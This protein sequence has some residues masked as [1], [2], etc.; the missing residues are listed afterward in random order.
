MSSVELLTVPQF[1]G[2]FREPIACSDMFLYNDADILAKKNSAII[3]KIKLSLF[4]P[5]EVGDKERSC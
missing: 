1:R 3:A 4:T 2:G 5:N